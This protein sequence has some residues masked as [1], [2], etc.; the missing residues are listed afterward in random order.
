L[1]LE[2]ARGKFSV[3]APGEPSILVL[4]VGSSTLKFGLFPLAEGDDPLLHGVL[5]YAGR[6]GGLL[7]LV[8]SGERK[9]E[10]VQVAATRE[11]GAREL[12]DYLERSSLFKSVRAVG[13]RLVHGG[14]K[15][16]APIVV[17]AAVR[18]LLE[19]VVPLAPDH[20]PTELGAMDEVAR[21]ASAVPQVACF[22]TAFHGAMPRV[23][24]LFGLPRSLLDSG[25][26]RYGFHG[27]SYEYVTDALR[28]RGE[29]PARTI[30]AHLGNGAS[31][32]AVRDGVGIDTTM[33]LTPTGGMVMSTRSGDLDPGILLYLLRSRGFSADGVDDATKHKGGLLGIS[34][35]SSDVRDLLAACANDPKAEEA[36]GVFCYQAKKFIGAYA[37]ALGGIDALVFT[38]GIGE[39]SPDVRARICEGLGFLGIEIDAASNGE[40]AETISATGSKVR[41]RTIKTN[42]EAMIA[43]HT[44][45]AVNP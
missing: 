18:A 37:A 1:A 8:Y 35:S 29:L 19:E 3:T 44:R 24:R 6:E 41:V 22:D 33:G 13:H 5:E 39:R 43:R 40:N 23:A 36:I 17:D 27:L 12:L 2:R 31:I 26:L 11:S 10:S 32:A 38:G 25:V 28:K 21:F 45:Q 9:Q 7:R 14:S 42:E 30:V 20:L 16:R 4:N 34:D 15:L